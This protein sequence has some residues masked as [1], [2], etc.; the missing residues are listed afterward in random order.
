MVV[1]MSEIVRQLVLDGLRHRHPDAS[2]DELRL[3]LI[4]RLHGPD[5]ALD[6]AARA[7]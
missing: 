4:E 5:V 1:E 7:Q 2:E 3:L 6:I